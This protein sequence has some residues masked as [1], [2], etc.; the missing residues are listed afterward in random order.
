MTE[1]NKS[2]NKEEGFAIPRENYKYMVIG[3]IIVIIGFLLML[4]GGSDDPKVF[5]KEMF[6][7][8]RIII[9]PI[10]VLLGYA[11]EVW[12]IMKKPKEL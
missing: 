6:N 12:V 9:A 7:T 1:K 3:F 10:V 2:I 8:Q 11:F 5:N 4:G